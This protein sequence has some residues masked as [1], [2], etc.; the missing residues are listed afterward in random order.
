MLARA[1]SL[2]VEA[3]VT[4]PDWQI[5][6]LT[7]TVPASRCRFNSAFRRARDRSAY[8]VRMTVSISPRYVNSIGSPVLP[9]PDD[10]AAI[11]AAG[12]GAATGMPAAEAV[13]VAVITGLTSVEFILYAVD[14]R[15]AAEA[16]QAVR[17]ALERYPVATETSRDP[18]WKTYRML[19]RERRR[20][21]PDLVVL[22][23]FPLLAGAMVAARYGRWW[24]MGEAV[25]CAAWIVPVAV[26]AAISARKRVMGRARKRAARMPA[27]P[28]RAFTLAAGVFTSLFFGLIALLAGLYL[29]A[30]ESLA[31]AVAAGLLVTAA[32]W[33]MQRRFDAMMR[34][35]LP[36]AGQGGVAEG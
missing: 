24:G 14:N 12:T 5:V 9:D 35:R 31:I 15:R 33:P 30:V 36:G 8:P 3:A 32:V 2:T 27:H 11:E 20:A 19:V 13:L 34:T 16:E 17:A 21:R 10:L 6:Q 25:A 4:S 22:P 23:L 1:K 26:L 7:S 28:G 29:T 18:R